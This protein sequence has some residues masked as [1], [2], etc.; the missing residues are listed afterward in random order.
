M[1]EML[2]SANALLAPFYHCSDGF[3]RQLQQIYTSP[4]SMQG[5]CQWILTELGK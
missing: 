4:P 2:K 5:L 3:T 1:T